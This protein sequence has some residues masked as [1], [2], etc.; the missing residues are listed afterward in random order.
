MATAKLSCTRRLAPEEDE[1]QHRQQE[2]LIHQNRLGTNDKRRIV[3]TNRRSD[4]RDLRRRHLPLHHRCRRNITKANETM[5]M[6]RVTN[7]PTETAHRRL[8]L[9]YCS[10]GDSLVPLTST[11]T[12]WK[13]SMRFV[14][15]RPQSPEGTATIIT[16]ASDTKTT[17]MVTA[18]EILRRLPPLLNEEK[19][20]QN[21]L[22]APSHKSF[23]PLQPLT[24]DRPQGRR[25][26]CL[27]KS[28]PLTEENIQTTIR[29]ETTLLATTET[30]VHNDRQQRRCRNR[31]TRRLIVRE[32]IRPT[33][34]PHP[35]STIS[36]DFKTDLIE[37][38]TTTTNRRHNREVTSVQTRHRA[39]PMTSAIST[40]GMES[41]FTTIGEVF[42]L[43][44]R[45]PRQRV[46]QV[47]V[48]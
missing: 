17:T 46:I 42:H 10:A 18:T 35:S 20:R 26:R 11:M 47:I 8:H 9:R 2:L 29:A 13:C 5:V 27:Q 33:S 45:K 21:R 34:R 39:H 6:M 40:I 36:T 23:R 32:L 12:I 44:R 14:P 4:P 15:R 16:I 25:R 24:R 43:L 3:E 31:H 48:N 38:D 41:Q 30:T 28:P 37:E 19:G 22:Q 7:C 1:H